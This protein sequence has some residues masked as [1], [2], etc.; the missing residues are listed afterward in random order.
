MP[1]LLRKI[2]LVEKVIQNFLSEYCGI[3]IGFGSCLLCYQLDPLN[4]LV[5]SW[6]ITLRV[7]KLAEHSPLN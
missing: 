6:V 3:K 4:A 5:N 2:E 1:R 7:I